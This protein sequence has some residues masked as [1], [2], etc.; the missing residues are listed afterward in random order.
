MCRRSH[1]L[2]KIDSNLMEKR[3]SAIVSFRFYFN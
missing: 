3:S 2:I 1:T